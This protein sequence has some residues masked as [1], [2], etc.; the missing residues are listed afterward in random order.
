MYDQCKHRLWKQAST[1]HDM[2]NEATQYV[3]R[4]ALSLERFLVQ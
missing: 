3:S 2:H 1:S 4:T